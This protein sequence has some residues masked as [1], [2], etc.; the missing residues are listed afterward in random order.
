MK[1]IK[2]ISI[3]ILVFCFLALSHQAR[4]ESGKEQAPTANTC[5]DC[6]VESESLP[7]DFN[8]EDIH[9]RTGLGCVGCHG[10]D[11]TA[12][13]PDEAMN[14]RKG[15]VGKPRPRDIP[16]FCGK[17]HS[18]IKFMRKYRPRI[19]TDQMEQYYTSQHGILLKKG[20][21]KVA[22][23][24]SCHTAHSIFEVKD[25]R[26]TVYPLNVP[27]TCNKCHGDP[28]YMK[29]YKIPTDQY[30]K[31]AKSVHGIALLKHRDIG[32]PACNDCHGNH[33]AMP[34]GVSSIAYVCGECHVNNLNYF[35]ESSMGKAFIEN[36]LHGC[37]ECHG[38]HDI[39]KPTDEMVGVGDHST[40]INCHDEGDA[41]FQAAKKIY[42]ELKESTTLYDS[43]KVQLNVIRRIG[44]DDVD[45]GYLIQKAEQSIIKARTL[46]HTF[47][48]EK[49][50]KETNLS[51]K[52]SKEALK[53]AEQQIQDSI[54]R[55]RG[56]GMATF[57]ILIL[58]VALY[59]KIRDLESNKGEKEKA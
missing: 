15:F 36:D 50:A 45:L 34:P 19:P 46:V 54:N 42:Q 38:H 43:A 12:D 14:P 2:K 28:Q 13:D 8:K 16:K 51:I 56:L 21:E 24:S 7:A 40:C 4:A 29:N 5:Y 31:Y 52:N 37:T 58:I 11:P 26:S 59:F 3:G 17:C 9:L 6:H 23:C 44:M 33:G 53:L 35:R 32:A 57:F 20:D 10:G 41:G 47:D 18:Q 25:S 30:R 1:F 48:P 49:V 22:V 55:R 27:R 39:D